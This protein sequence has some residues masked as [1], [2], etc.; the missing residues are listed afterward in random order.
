LTG[1]EIEA[2]AVMIGAVPAALFL[3]ATGTPEA[4]LVGLELV[5]GAVTVA[6]L[7]VAQVVGQSYE[8]IVPL[9]LVV[10]SVVGTLVFTRL[11][12]SSGDRA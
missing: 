2:A 7:I 5:T 11:L 8:L 1:Y 12:G 3:T 9:V 4:R 6:M 10:L